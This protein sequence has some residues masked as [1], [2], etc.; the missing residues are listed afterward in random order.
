MQ[1]TGGYNRW[2]IERNYGGFQSTPLVH[3]SAQGRVGINHATPDAKLHV[4]GAYNETGAI[5]TGGALGYND[6]LQCKTANGHAR[7]TVA[8]NGEIYGPTS[9]RKNWF[10]NGSFDCTFGGRKNNTSMDHGNHHAMDG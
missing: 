9:G 4:S 6:V 3:L 2:N 1:D 7:L 8:G 10:D 5:I